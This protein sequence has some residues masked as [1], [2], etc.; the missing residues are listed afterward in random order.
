VSI[1]VRLALF[2]LGVVALTLVL[3]TLLFFVLLA[4][5]SANQQDK[6]LSTR[7]EQALAEL[8]A[9]PPHEF[10]AE[11][12]LA[13][14]DP[15]TALDIFI[16]VLG[17]GGA[18]LS[19]TGEVNGA[20]P[21]IPADVLAAADAK[22]KAVTTI[23]AAPGL[24]LRV[25]VRPWSRPELGLRGHVAVL[26]ST[27][28]VES[29]LRGGRAFL[30]LAAIFAFLVAAVAIWLVIGRALRPL[31]Q[32]AALTDEVGAT[33]DLSRR[34]PVPHARDEVRRLSESF[35][36]MMTR[37]QAAYG[38][39]AEALASQKR[40]VAD[41]SHE[42]RTPLTTIRSNT[43]FLIQRPDAR[44]EDRQAALQDIAGESE[45]MSRLV[46]D[47]LTLA[48][49]DA[50]YHLEKAA[51]DLFAIASEVSRQARNLHP[52][53]DIAC[54]GDAVTMAANEDALKQLLW[55]L[56]ENAVR[57]TGEGGHVR[58]EVARQG[59][60]ARL[61]VIDDGEG[62]PSA[63]LERIFDRFYQADAARSGSGAGLGLAIAR[64]IAEE[65]GGSISAR[66]N[67]CRGATFSV[68]LP[69]AI[70]EAMAER[71]KVAPGQSASPPAQRLSS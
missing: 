57:H 2:G 50:G 41:A 22:G 46:Q 38:Q 17:P 54:T 1:R 10:R 47:L 69:A 6:Q 29:E 21:A 65:H 39:L 43:G 4:A 5:G 28:S 19:A 64:W 31:N 59:G 25:H 56:I 26:Q 34:L 42:L 9:A 27:R 48:R 40:F 16:V 67:R 15:A 49:A 51:V 52:Q 35:N 62:I 66:N 58:I 30:I 53:R 55:I 61:N 71:D 70:G 7:A 14:V 33:Q 24:R 13:P 8:A 44:A 23:E 45:R 60:G 12:T 32:L 36:A 18:T 37:L 20:P 63:D 68:E 11:Q 3:F